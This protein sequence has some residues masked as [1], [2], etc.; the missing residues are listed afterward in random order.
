MTLWETVSRTSPLEVGSHP[1]A[2]ASFCGQCCKVTSHHHHQME[3]CAD[4]RWVFSAFL[5]FRLKAILMYN[6]VLCWV[7]NLIPYM[8]GGGK[9]SDS[10]LLNYNLLLNF[11]RDFHLGRL[12][13]I[14]WCYQHFCI[15]NVFFLWRK[16]DK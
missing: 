7:S 12:V 10:Y 16:I 13:L 8:K 11:L 2:A 15:L 1:E 14:W 4:Q 6:V 9:F 3:G 5:F